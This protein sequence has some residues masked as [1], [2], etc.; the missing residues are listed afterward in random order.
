MHLKY[1]IACLLF[2]CSIG[3]YAS[4]DTFYRIMPPHTDTF[5]SN[6]PH[7]MRPS[8]ERSYR[9]TAVKFLAGA[10][11]QMAKDRNDS[12]YSRKL[13]EIG[14]HRTVAF[15]GLQ[16]P[17]SAVTIGPSLEFS[18]GETPVYGFKFGGWI[19]ANLLT[20]GISSIYYTDFHRGNFKIRP[21]I[22]FG[23][24]AAKLTMG[25]NIPTIANGDF[26]PL[27]S[28]LLQISFNALLKVKT[29]KKEYNEVPE[30]E[31]SGNY[32]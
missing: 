27:K 29:I 12:A 26:F 5:Y 1:I 28:S 10:H 6:R 19:N 24:H 21:E 17:K 32:N 18:L 9:E 30:F 20:L 2:V 8:G 16:H 14:I 22:G 11:L 23:F 3:S 13:L 4:V 15:D 7:K 25:L 31:Q